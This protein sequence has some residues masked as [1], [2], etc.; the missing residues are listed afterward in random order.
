MASKDTKQSSVVVENQPRQAAMV[1]PAIY[2]N[3]F[4]LA[5]NPDITRITFGEKVGELA[6]MHSSIAVTTAGAE[7]LANIILE[8][9][10]KN[11]QE[12]PDKYPIEIM[13]D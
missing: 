10:E 7:L 8:S 2:S 11:K 6:N 9:I 4:Q 12:N 3:H 13:E 1:I 5:V